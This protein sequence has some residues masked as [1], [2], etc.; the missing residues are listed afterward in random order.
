MVVG[1]GMLLVVAAAQ[2]ATQVLAQTPAAALA[3]PVRVQADAS[4]AT[5]GRVQAILPLG[6][7]IYIGGSFTRVR[8]LG[9]VWVVRPYLAALDAATGD[10][11]PGFAPSPDGPVQA[12]AGDA[13][14]TRLLV[15]GV[16]DRI[17]GAPHR[18]LAVLEPAS[19]AALGGSSVDV[20]GGEI[21][22]LAVVGQRVFL[23]GKFIQVTDAAGPHTRRR[24]AAVDLAS[25]LVLAGWH[26]DPDRAVRALAPSPDG[27]TLY[28][29]GSFTTIA[30]SF[31]RKLAA[32][33]P[34]SGR[35]L[36]YLADP[37]ATVI[38]L[39]A[40]A[41]GLFAAIGGPGGRCSAFDPTTGQTRW[42]VHANGNVQ[43]VALL[44]GLVYCGGH[45]NGTRSFGD[46]GRYKLAAVDAA[47]GTIASFAPRLD[48]AL[49]VFALATNGPH[50]EVGGDFTT[51]S[52]TAQ[53]H[54]AQFTPDRAAR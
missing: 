46:V 25:G 23:G 43:A 52:G 42:S 7:R 31:R 33:D 27:Q 26:P 15:A 4:A 13:S 32:L 48:S 49:G 19:G 53:E 41:A 35:L 51:V 10:L 36:P 16:Y 30:G 54:Y 14:G 29:G 20:D 2:V 12:L 5:D 8:T 18:Q 6:S 45:F 39:Q 40:T 34:V 28:M 44:G 17:G 1:L 37:Q 50:L 21:L 38:G 9:G 3:N 47:N 22:A 24:A 11:D